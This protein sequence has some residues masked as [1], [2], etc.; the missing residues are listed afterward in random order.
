M[1]FCELNIRNFRW[2]KNYRKQGWKSRG[3]IVWYFSMD[4]EIILYRTLFEFLFLHEFRSSGERNTKMPSWVFDA[5]PRRVLRSSIKSPLSRN[6]HGREY[7]S[8]W[9]NCKTAKIR[10]TYLSEMENG[11]PRHHALHLSITHPSGWISSW[12]FTSDNAFHFSLG[13]AWKWNGENYLSSFFFFFFIRK[14]KVFHWNLSNKNLE[15]PFP[16]I[17]SEDALSLRGSPPFLIDVSCYFGMLLASVV[18]VVSPGFQMRFLDPSI[19]VFLSPYCRGWKIYYSR[20]F[21][22]GNDGKS[23]I[24]FEKSAPK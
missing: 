17:L 21:F 9:I 22:T 6:N 10:P 1:I 11:T 20:H 16:D 14:V 4:K 13:G 24:R 18:S 12:L 5:R 15:I 23:Y 2:S 3:N 8:G 19:K 7:R